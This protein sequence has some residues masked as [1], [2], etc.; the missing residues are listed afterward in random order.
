MKY[1]S[2]NDEDFLQGV[3]AKTRYLEYLRDEEEL[4]KKNCRKIR[5]RRIKIIIASILIAALGI[6]I[7]KI[8]KFDFQAVWI[9][10]ITI[11]ALACFYEYR[12]ERFIA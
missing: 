2:K 4:V 10:S 9:I 6:F 7:M 11:L 12:E 5:T 3:W 8:T 1:I